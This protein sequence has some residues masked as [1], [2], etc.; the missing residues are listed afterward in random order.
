VVNDA[1]VTKK[2]PVNQDALNK[3]FVLSPR[4]TKDD[5]N[6]WMRRFSLEVLKESPLH[7]LRACSSLAAVYHP[8]AREL[9]NPAFLSVWSELYAQVQV[10]DHGHFVYSITVFLHRLLRKMNETLSYFF[11]FL[12]CRISL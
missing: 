7:A 3:S 9:L 1:A 2:I 11:A 6:D 12:T 4:P 5:W 8:L 10:C